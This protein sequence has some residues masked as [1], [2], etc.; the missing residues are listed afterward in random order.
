MT[1]P[2]EESEELD[3]RGRRR[4]LVVVGPLD[5]ALEGEPRV[6]GDAGDELVARGAVGRPGEDRRVAAPL[7]GV[8]HPLDVGPDLAVGGGAARVEVPD[9]LPAVGPEADLLADVRCP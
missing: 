2:D 1:T 4:L 5:L 8:Q 3:R 7:E 9:H 6:P